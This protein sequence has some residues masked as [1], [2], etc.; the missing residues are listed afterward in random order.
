M[1]SRKTSSN[2]PKK[3][4]AKVKTPKASAPTLET[5]TN[6]KGNK[7]LV[8]IL[9]LIV[10]VFVV[11]AVVKSFKGSKSG[12]ANANG[13]SESTSSMMEKSA[14]TESSEFHQILTVKENDVVFGKSDAPVEIYEYASLS[15][16]HCGHFFTTVFKKI[17]EAYIDTGKAK[18]IYR[19]FP[20]HM[21]AVKAAMLVRC[22]KRS[23]DEYL[24]Y[25]T[26]LYKTQS[27]WLTKDYAEKLQTISALAGTPK[28]EFNKC[29][30][31]KLIEDQVMQM[32]LDASKYLAI[33]STPT[34]FINK[35]RVAIHSFEEISKKID[36]S[37]Q[38]GV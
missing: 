15:C 4:T 16:S 6:V 14:A 12:E 38:Q 9:S 30:N 18:F 32:Y 36:E 22:K 13:S 23:Q 35:K 17:K 11:I 8:I 31:D 37:L 27:D 3:S 33:N 24:K 21:E 25:L 2:A 5:S 34:I 29:L 7:K 1:P 19:D 20:L 10:A 26:T 28:Q